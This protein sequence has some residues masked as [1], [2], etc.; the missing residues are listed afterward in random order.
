M[1]KLYF[2]IFKG[3]R[4]SLAA[5]L[6]ICVALPF[7]TPISFADE[8]IPWDLRQLYGKQTEFAEISSILRDVLHENGTKLSLVTGIQGEITQ[9]F[10]RFPLQGVFNMIIEEYSLAYRY[11]PTTNTVTVFDPKKTRLDSEQ[12]KTPLT[13]ADKNKRA[14]TAAQIKIDQEIGKQKLLE[15]TATARLQ[16][17]K[18]LETIRDALMKA[19]RRAQKMAKNN[20]P[21]IEQLNALK[22]AKNY[23]LDYRKAK[24]RH[25]NEITELKRSSS[26]E[27]VSPTSMETAEADRKMQL[28]IQGMQKSH[29]RDIERLNTQLSATA[30]SKKRSDDLASKKQKESSKTIAKLSTTLK[31]QEL[32]L[33]KTR[34]QF[35]LGR[36]RQEQQIAALRNDIIKQQNQRKSL[37]IKSKLALNKQEKQKLKFEKEAVFLRGE[38]EKL[39]LKNSKERLQ[40]KQREQELLDKISEA[41][42]ASQNTEHPNTKRLESQQRELKSVLTQLKEMQQRAAV[43]SLLAQAKSEKREE[44]LSFTIKRLQQ[45]KNRAESSTKLAEAERLQKEQAL[46]LELERMQLSQKTA[47]DEIR[48]AQEMRSSREK[49]LNT[50]LE[51]MRLQQE[52]IESEAALASATRQQKEQELSHKLRAMRDANKQSNLKAE[53]DLGTQKER[54]RELNQKLITM[55]DA[56][57]EERLLS[58]M[59]LAVQARKER[60]LKEKMAEL[61]TIQQQK[62]LDSQQALLD[63]T[64]EIEV[65]NKTFAKDRAQLKKVL[66]EYR[67]EIFKIKRNSEEADTDIPVK[68]TS[69]SIEK[70]E[71][72]TQQKAEDLADR[73]QTPHR[74][75]D[76]TWLYKLV[77][78]GKTNGTRFASIDGKDYKVGDI[79]DHMKITAIERDYVIGIKRVKDQPTQYKIAF[80]K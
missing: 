48:K 69:G 6:F 52:K 23:S 55:R 19:E 56:Q 37:D 22:A 14:L 62:E 26:T 63:K 36:M 3:L 38:K 8:K 25:S 53:L 72:S 74:T 18:E 51:K 28:K 16:Q 43:E 39:Q 71:S 64:D 33:D 24:V 76:A 29:K 57:N 68:T 1:L 66:D 9:D 77:G 75:I 47:E 58:E 73:T 45:E 30:A 10:S 44:Q 15:A 4:H 78:I 79:F 42:S 40:Q 35:V 2:P 50:R 32:S 60:L 17:Y 70:D 21:L 59:R 12:K 49:E 54:E 61:K 5:L 27:A 20:S 67:A 46:K 31:Q 80:R 11:D 13:K 34:A 7:T 65:Q 41:R